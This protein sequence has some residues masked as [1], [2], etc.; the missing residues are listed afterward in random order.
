MPKLP[1]LTARRIIKL[2]KRNGFILDHA[3]G[4]HYI[5]YNAARDRHVTVPYHAKDLPKGTLLSILDQ[6][7]LDRKDII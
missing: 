5:F 2:L 6:A 3:T 4:A 7:G 1:V